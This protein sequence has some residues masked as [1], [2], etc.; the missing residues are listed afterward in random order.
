M[1]VSVIIPTH[2]RC[3][4]LKEALES[5]IAQSY[6]NLEIIVI[7]NNSL[8]E[9]QK[10]IKK[11]KD[12][13]IKYKRLKENMGAAFARNEGLKMSNGDYIAFLDDDDL[14]FPQKT[15]IQLEKFKNSSGQVGLIYAWSANFIND[16][17]DKIKAI[18]KC[19]LKGA[20]SVYLLGACMFTTST[21]LIK[22]EYIKKIGYFDTSLRICEDIDFFLR[23]SKVCEF[24]YVPQILAK[25]RIHSG[26][27]TSLLSLSENYLMEFLRRTD[28]EVQK[29]SP[30]SL[31]NKII[32][33]RHMMLA[34]FY[35]RKGDLFPARNNF[36][37]A[38]QKN[39]FIRPDCYINLFFLFFG[40]RGMYLSQK[41]IDKILHPLRRILLIIFSN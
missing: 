31:K 19:K 16:N 23:L 11:F 41:L 24:D 26:N 33:K 1:L 10:I 27:T 37:K 9:T 20:V 12:T 22:K 18:Q 2:N 25:Y 30:P 40:K 13:R 17:S 6:S 38:I 3:N 32:S 35:M 39:A 34:F 8:Y 7:D 4:Y 15:E 14:W 36:W 28:K 5:V 29:I 21:P